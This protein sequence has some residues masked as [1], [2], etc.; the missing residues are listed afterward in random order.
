ERVAPAGET[1]SFSGRDLTELAPAGSESISHAVRQG[2]WR[3]RWRVRG[4]RCHIRLPGA[5]G[6][7]HAVVSSDAAARTTEGVPRTGP[8]GSPLRFPRCG[9]RLVCPGG[10]KVFRG[11]VRNDPNLVGEAAPDTR[12]MEGRPA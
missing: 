9:V 3:I 2:S 1:E 12:A 11:V 8:N 7:P 6:L 5:T 4:L 10:A